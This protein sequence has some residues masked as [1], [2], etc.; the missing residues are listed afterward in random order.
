[1][2]LLF[3]TRYD[4]FGASSRIR[5][6][7]YFDIL[8][9]NG[10]DITLS[11]FLN[12]NYLDSLY[13]KKKSSIKL[14]LSSYFK[15]VLV[16]IKANKFDLIIVEKEIFPWMP[17]WAEQ[18]LSAFN[19]KY[20]VD[21]DDA[22]FHNYDLNNNHFIKILLKNKIKRVIA[23]SA[24]VIAGN[25]Y[26]Y[27][28]AFDSKAKK[29]HLIPTV[30]DF[31]RYKNISKNRNNIF[32]VGWIGSPSTVKYLDIVK[33]VLIKLLNFIN[34][35]LV[36]IGATP[37][38]FFNIPVKVLKWSEDTEVT[39]ISQF[40]VGIMPLPDE[41]W[42]KGKCGYKLIQYLACGIP[43]I[44]SPIGVNKEIVETEKNGFL[45]NNEVEWL[46]ALLT[47]HNSPLLCKEFGNY[48]RNKVIDKYSLQSSGQLFVEIVNN[49][50]KP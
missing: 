12:S 19:I 16:L 40:D 45:A 31:N 10:Y 22:I 44:C 5:F 43:V 6:I 18:L 23:S 9:N 42:E 50:C 49:V 34:F 48:G 7:Q 3:L 35:E 26:I 41:P 20:I 2:K 25:K 21:F 17:S 39:N 4:N 13:S 1:M 46:N 27:N 47:L 29:I 30:I 8:R 15:R 38:N 24:C 36:V 37:N 28:Y 14:I 33:P 32:T 11:P